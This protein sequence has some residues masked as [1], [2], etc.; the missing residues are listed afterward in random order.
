[1]NNLEEAQRLATLG[2]RVFSRIQQ[3][4]T[5]QSHPS[6]WPVL[7]SHDHEALARLMVRRSRHTASLCSRADRAVCS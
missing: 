1:M 2:Y 5:M 4:S 6:H 3:R 7:A